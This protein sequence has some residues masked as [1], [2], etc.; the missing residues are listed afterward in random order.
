[1][2]LGVATGFFGGWAMARPLDR[3]IDGHPWRF[4][5]GWLVT[6]AIG[7]GFIALGFLVGR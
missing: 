1:M 7:T 6:A 4:A 3:H 5:V 2:A